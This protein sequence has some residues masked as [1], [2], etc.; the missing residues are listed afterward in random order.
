MTAHAASAAYSGVPIV[1]SGSKQSSGLRAVVGVA[2]G[3]TTSCAEE[4]ERM[5]VRTA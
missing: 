4:W 5:A 3:R 1:A 2:F